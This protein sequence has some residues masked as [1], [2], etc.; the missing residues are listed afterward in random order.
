MWRRRHSACAV[1]ETSPLPFLPPAPRRDSLEP[2]TQHFGCRARA[3]PAAHQPCPP[4][5]RATWSSVLP[6]EPPSSPTQVLHPSSIPPTYPGIRLVPDSLGSAPG[7][8]AG[9]RGKAGTPSLAAAPGAG[10]EALPHSGAVTGDFVTA[11]P[12]TEGRGKSDT[13]VFVLALFPITVSL[14]SSLNSSS[15]F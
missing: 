3:A 7:S 6:S 10:T 12:C 5:R 11:I 13:V 15:G 9:H 14:L 2:H 1:V 4:E 8:W